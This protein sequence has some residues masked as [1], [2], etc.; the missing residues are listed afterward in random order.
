MIY[1]KLATAL[2]AASLAAAAPLMAQSP[3][4]AD[5]TVTLEKMEVNDV[6][7]EQQILPTTR[8]F[9]SVFGTA[10]SIMETPRNVT[11]ISREQ[12]TAISIQDVRDFAKLTSSSYTRTNF[13]A[14]GN[15]DIRGQ[16]AD[17]FM[18]GM[19]ERITSN[20]NGMPI[21]FNAVE[22][23]N[24]VKGPATVVQGVSTYVGG[25]VDLITKR[26]FFDTTKTS[27]Y[28]TV[29][30][31]ETRRWGLDTGGPVS[32]KLAYRVSYSGE[33]SEGYYYDSYTK[34]QSLYGAVTWKPSEQYE[35]FINAQAAYMEYV[36]NFGIN[37]PTQNLIDNGLY[38][39]GTNINGGTT[40][41]AADPQNAAHIDSGGSPFNFNTIAYGPEVPIDR[42]SR[43]LRPGDNSIGR[44]FKIQAIQS[45]F[46]SP[47]LTVVNNNM[48]TYTRRETLSSYH[49]SEIIDPSYTVESRLEFQ[50][51]L[52][53]HA[54][55]FGVDAR[56]QNVKAYADFFFEP[57]AAWDITKDR[58][59]INAYKSV[60]FASHFASY[61]VPGWENRYGSSWVAFGG[62]SGAD[63]NISSAIFGAPFAQATWALGDKLK[64]L[65]GA[66]VDFGK[67]KARDPFVARYE[68]TIDVALPNANVSLNYSFTPKATA[69]ATYNYS[70][71]TSGA[72]G[73]GG[74]YGGGY[75]YVPA[76]DTIYLDKDAFSQPSEL[77]EL[78]TKY[79]LFGEKLFVGASL[80]QQT[81]QQKQQQGPLLTYR[82]RGFET[83]AN[84][85]PNK[86]LYATFSWALIEATAPASA[87]AAAFDP[88]N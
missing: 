57:A 76:T 49:Y 83:E 51:K 19:R 37:R 11:I 29:G 40:A 33:D 43:L 28:A 84:F 30:S 2:T 14:P 69:Y 4:P 10:G 35:L 59:G 66:R 88:A 74:G 12:L 75:V 39:T 52:G 77:A 9:S 3:A 18:N 81:R 71:N 73:N 41:T 36:E 22:S 26:P 46:T 53:V 86:H 85:Q 44:N 62:E 65:T 24:I 6:P 38:R 8:P 63:G 56:Y 31:Y 21:D 72:A 47:D 13:G 20:G 58:S 25:F 60:N 70:E 78:G 55:N 23:V 79:S 17:V 80:F 32:D 82:Y 68:D 15:P 45:F 67:I 1:R 27:V 50:K 48:F 61:K 64:V 5:E 54:I 87:V 34:K 16:S 7:L 42:R